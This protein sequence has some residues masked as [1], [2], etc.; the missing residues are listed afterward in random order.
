V[1]IAD[2]RPVTTPSRFLSMPSSSLAI[3]T[4]NASMPSRSSLSVTSSRSIP[5]SRS[6]SR[7]GVGSSSAPPPLSSPSLPAASNVGS[8]I[9]LTVF[10]AARPQTYSVSGYCGFLT[11]VEAHSGRCTGAPAARS[12]AK[13]S[14]S[15]TRLNAW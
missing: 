1:S 11:P 3:G 8:G 2:G 5:A 4:R 6:A 7:S 12:S 9:V 15:N 10:G 13:R 14:P